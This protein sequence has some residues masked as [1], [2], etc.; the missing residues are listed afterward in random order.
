MKHSY[1]LI[2]LLFLLFAGCET[3]ELVQNALLKPLEPRD[4]L[5]PP[6]ILDSSQEFGFLHSEVFTVP[7]YT[8]IY[9]AHAESDTEIVHPSGSRKDT[10][11]RNQPV[12]VLEEILEGGE[13]L[14]IFATGS[15]RNVPVP[16]IVFDPNGGSSRIQVEQTLGVRSITGNIGA[17]VGLFDN[18]KQ[19]FLIGQRKQ[20]Y[21]PSGA[22]SLYLAFLDYPGYSSDN[23][24]EYIVS[25]DV[26]RR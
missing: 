20:I 17:L 25:I 15:A 4:F 18:Q 9:L 12:K 23:E 8:N 3:Q 10:W 13:V 16:S 24:G 7:A 1:I 2:N 11:Q 22:E 26:I 6:K 5:K 19:P 14:D 21:V